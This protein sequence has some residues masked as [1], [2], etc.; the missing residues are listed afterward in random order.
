MKPIRALTFVVLLLLFSSS[1]RGQ[2]KPNPA[3]VLWQTLSPGLSFLRWEVHSSNNMKNNTLAVLRIDPELWS[4]R[5]FFDRETKTIKEWQ[6]STRATVICNGGYYQEN[7]QPAGRILVNGT[8]LG[9]F[10]NRHMKGM[11]LSEPKKGF[12][13]LPKSTLIDLKDINSEEKISS[14]EQGIQS[15]PILL[16]PAGQVR[17]NSSNFQANRTVLAQDHSGNIYILITEKPSFTLYDFGNYL[18]GSPFGFR[19]ILN[20]D[21]GL[22]TQLLIQI[23][24]FKYLFT[25]QGEGTGTPLLFFPEPVKLPSVI[26][27][28]PRG[29]H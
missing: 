26:G 15:F 6:Q 25:G 22:R 20:L 19:F 8:S 18:K 3:P 10:K 9:P 29:H 13:T 16:D 27:L 21:G 23:K 5:V 12:E 7:F 14:Y 11:F 1:L 28:F 2:E 24:G 4:F 17:V